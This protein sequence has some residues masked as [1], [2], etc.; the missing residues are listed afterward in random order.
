MF[1]TEFFIIL[2]G[3]TDL[4]LYDIKN[5]NQNLYFTISGWER[6]M[7]FP[8]FRLIYVSKVKEIILFWLGFAGSRKTGDEAHL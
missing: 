3:N 6:E 2:C 4:K 1:F 5:T 8:C 7:I